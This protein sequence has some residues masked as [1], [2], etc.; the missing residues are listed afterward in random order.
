MCQGRRPGQIEKVSPFR[1]PGER[2]L[3]E[4][5]HFKLHPWEVEGKGHELQ[6]QRD[7]FTGKFQELKTKYSY[8]KYLSI[9][10][11]NQSEPQPCPICQELLGPGKD[12]LITPCGAQGP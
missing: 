11:Q 6:L 10:D 12:K 8:L 7:D 9:S 1:Q 3:P 5:E 4:E 2:V